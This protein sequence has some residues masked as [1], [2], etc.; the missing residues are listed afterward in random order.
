MSPRL[1]DFIG[2]DSHVRPLRM[3]TREEGESWIAWMVGELNQE[4]SIV[5]MARDFADLDSLFVGR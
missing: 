2:L 1:K 4:A 3:P 5:Q